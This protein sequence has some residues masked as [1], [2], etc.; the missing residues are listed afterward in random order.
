M[1]SQSPVVSRQTEPLLHRWEYDALL[2]Q[3]V[4]VPLPF[5]RVPSKDRC[6]GCGARVGDEE[7][8]AFAGNDLA[9]LPKGAT[10]NLLLW[11]RQGF[12][13]GGAN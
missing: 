13:L 4:C 5:G 8:F 12:V 11:R 9:K 10:L 1:S 6:L 2:H 3:W 7:V